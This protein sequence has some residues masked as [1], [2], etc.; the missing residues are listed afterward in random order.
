MR[1]KKTQKEGKRSNGDT[2]PRVNA[3]MGDGRN[4]DN[5]F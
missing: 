3:A 5:G 4:Y 1:Q 2:R